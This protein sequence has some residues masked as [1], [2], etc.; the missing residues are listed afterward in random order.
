MKLLSPSGLGTRPTTSRVR[1][2]V[3]N[4]LSPRIS[5][6]N[7]LELCSGSGVMS[8]EALQRGAK[9]IVAVERN[10]K[11][12]RICKANLLKTASGIKEQIEI[13][14]VQKE[15]ISW[16]KNGS[17][18]K[19]PKTFIS[20]KPLSRKGFDLIYFDPPYEST[21]YLPV[22]KE[23]HRG[24]W[25]N[26]NALLICELSKENRLLAPQPWVKRDRRVYGNTAILL[27]SLP[28]HHP[29]DIDSMQQQI[30]QQ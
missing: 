10:S 26:R 27:L 5:G 20:D 22:L 1:E 13:E 28:S 23:L 15:L 4:L 9:K 21:L 14:V 29:V 11:T 3:M 16:L 24:I 19:I 18:P 7:W 2:A 17:T 6:S 8:C 25:L 12:A 30:N